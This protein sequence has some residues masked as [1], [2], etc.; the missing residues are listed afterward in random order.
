MP[1]TNPRGKPETPGSQVMRWGPHGRPL[2]A[3]R[4]HDLATE[5]RQAGAWQEATDRRGP[6]AGLWDGGRGSQAVA[7]APDLTTEH[8]RTVNLQTAA[9]V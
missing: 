6:R 9:R 7:G 8:L 5:E 3:D 2:S 4:L 1:L